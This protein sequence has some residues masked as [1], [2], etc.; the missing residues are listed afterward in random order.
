M[1]GIS[2]DQAQAYIDDNPR[3]TYSSKILSGPIILNA[4]VI[5]PTA[6]FGGGNIIATWILVPLL[7]VLV[8]G[9]LYLTDASSEHDK[10][11]YLLYLGCSALLS[12]MSCLTAA[13]KVLSLILPVPLLGTL[14]ILAIYLLGIILL[15][16]HRCQRIRKGFYLNQATNSTAKPP[17]L[18]HIVIPLVITFCVLI[19]APA[20]KR[21]VNTHIIFAVLSM[22]LLMLAF[23]MMLG[24]QPLLKYYLIKKLINDRHK[25]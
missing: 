21:S 3:M 1:L 2:D 18:A 12:S 4:V 5:I 16:H 24:V 25:P 22:L 8:F 20:I 7:A 9:A 19:L 6:F 13:H 15:I 23:V 10:A 17:T 11:Q 14:A